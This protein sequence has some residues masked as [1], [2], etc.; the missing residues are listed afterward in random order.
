ML[1]YLQKE[2]SHLS[3]PF[4]S[5]ATTRS[6]VS[7]PLL[8]HTET[9]LRK[10]IR[11]KIKITHDKKRKTEMEFSQLK[12]KPK[13]TIKYGKPR[14]IKVSKLEIVRSELIGSKRGKSKRNYG[15]SALDFRSFFGIKK[16][17]NIKTNFIDPTALNIK[18]IKY[19]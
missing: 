13:L 10:H 18:D 11:F 1:T 17:R 15:S 2:H 12:P 19:I 8:Q 14:P 5:L 7:A 3:S 4:I 9:A 6:E 16:V